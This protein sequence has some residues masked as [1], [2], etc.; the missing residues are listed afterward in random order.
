MNVTQLINDNG[1]AVKNQFIIT[2]KDEV[3]FQSYDSKIATYHINDGTLVLYG[4]MWDYSNTTRKHFKQFVNKFTCYR[5]ETRTQ[6]LDCVDNAV[7][8]CVVI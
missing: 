6:W 4:N 3:T 8:I 5:Y 2:S 7:L 1:N